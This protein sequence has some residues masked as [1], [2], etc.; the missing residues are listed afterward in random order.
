MLTI[1]RAQRAAL[2]FTSALMYVVWLIGPTAA[3]N[4]QDTVAVPDRVALTEPP[5]IP[6]RL[7]IERDPFAG[8]PSDASPGAQSSATFSNFLPHLQ[9]DTR[10][11]EL[12]VP[13]I[14]AAM[15]A[16]GPPPISSTLVLKATIVGNDSV[17]YLQDGTSMKIVRVGDPIGERLVRA[18]DLAG[19]E[20]DDGSRLELQ[21]AGSVH[22][23]RLHA[24]SLAEDVARRVEFLLKR[25]AQNLSGSPA[26]K[27][28]LPSAADTPR[29]VD[30]LVT[31]GPLPTVVPDPLPI[32]TSPSNSS[33]AASPY[34]LPPLRPPDTGLHS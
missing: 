3:L 24:P 18:I 14:D 8:A 27:L 25:Q 10:H 23:G 31:P 2:L 33:P 6:V 19:V 16:K 15:E 9:P 22:H 29:A 32:G 21:A 20:L 7:A 13:N 1:T 34:P 28:V 17:A 4:A 11:Q 5:S 30:S 12:L 26:G